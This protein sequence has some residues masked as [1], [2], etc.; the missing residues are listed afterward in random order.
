MARRF[1]LVTQ[2]P[3][4]ECLERLKRST[5]PPPLFWVMPAERAFHCKITGHKIRLSTL[6]PGQPYN[7]LMP[8]LY[9]TLR[10][11]PEGTV[12]HGRL[13]P[14]GLALALMVPYFVIALGTAGFLTWAAVTGHGIF[15]VPPAIAILTPLVMAGIGILVARFC[16]ALGRNQEDQLLRFL[17]ETLEADQPA[18]TPG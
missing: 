9:A 5:S 4:E 6:G 16:V 11:T 17:G 13:R 2:L 18:H 3:V 1:E 15:K 12:V 14:H 7:T 8:F 10:D